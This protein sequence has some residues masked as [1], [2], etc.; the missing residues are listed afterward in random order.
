ML[1]VTTAPLLEESQLYEIQKAAVEL[2]VEHPRC[3]VLFE[4]GL[5][6]TISVGTAVRRLAK[7]GEIRRVLVVCPPRVIGVFRR[8]LKKWQHT[9]DISVIDVVGTPAERLTML[10]NPGDGIYCLSFA[11]LSWFLKHTHQ[12]KPFQMLVVDESSKIGDPSSVTTRNVVQLASAIT[13]CVIM[14]GTPGDLPRI[15]SQIFTLDQGKRLGSK[16]YPYLERTCIQ[17]GFRWIP[18]K[19]MRE[20]VSK[21]ISDFCHSA[22]VVDHVGTLPPI[23][24]QTIT[25]EMPAAARV[26]Y[27]QMEL[28]M[29]SDL[30]G[31]TVV[32]TNP[33]VVTGKLMQ[34]ADGMVYRSDGTAELIHTAKLDAVKALVDECGP[35]D[36]NLILYRFKGTAEAL[37][38]EL[39]GSEL[40]KVDTP[41]SMDR[42][43]NRWIAGEIPVLVAH[44]LSCGHGIDQLQLGGHRMIVFPGWSSDAHQQAI[45]RLHRAGGKHTVIVTTIVCADTIDEVIVK[46]LNAK[47]LGE[48]QLFDQLGEYL[49]NRHPKAAGLADKLKG[50]MKRRMDAHPDRGGSEAEFRAAHAEVERLKGGSA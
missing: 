11:V 18:R 21:K 29:L 46:S 30:A 4:P 41:A 35:D 34:I 1:P 49:K 5:G 32:A 8:E 20:A 16:Y 31:G 19:G 10:K 43:L 33:T 38:K 45:A 17:A 27:D 50:A 2:I 9:A 22:R 37:L 7:S 12:V 24:H 26:I 39:P 23:I 47:L 42:L 28:E 6:K 14:S 15:W 40:F 44:P 25:V 48:A 36:P 3:G 13:R